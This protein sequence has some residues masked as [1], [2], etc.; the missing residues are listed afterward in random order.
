MSDGDVKNCQKSSD[1]I[2]GW[3]LI[4]YPPFE[5]S[6][7]RIARSDEAWRLTKLR[8]LHPLTISRGLELL[9]IRQILVFPFPDMP[10]D[11]SNRYQSLKPRPSEL[12]RT[13]VW[14]NFKHLKGQ[15]ISKWLFGVFNFPKKTMPNLMNLCL[16][17]SWKMALPIF[18]QL[19]ILLRSASTSWLSL[20]TDI[21]I[22]LDNIGKFDVS[23]T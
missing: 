13:V 23:V 7:T 1:I 22:R 10:R 19:K 14:R 9:S 11:Q 2:Y 6:K 16:R 4:L 18:T 5:N 15:L 3:S 21:P 8:L 20:F 12:K 17:N